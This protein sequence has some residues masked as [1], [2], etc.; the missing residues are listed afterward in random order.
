MEADRSAKKIALDVWQT[1]QQ[2]AYE[3]VTLVCTI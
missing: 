3:N 2:K 1:L